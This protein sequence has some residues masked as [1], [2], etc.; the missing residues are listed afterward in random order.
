MQGPLGFS[1]TGQYILN[2][3][4]TIQRLVNDYIIDASGAA[5]AGYTISEAGVQFTYF[6]SKEYEQGGFYAA[7]GGKLFLNLLL[8]GCCVIGAHF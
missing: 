2:G 3:V 5:A 8:V 6:P 7:I 4:L 1:C